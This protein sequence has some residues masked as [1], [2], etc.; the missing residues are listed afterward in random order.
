LGTSAQETGT[1]GAASYG[2][3]GMGLLGLSGQR[4]DS[5]LVSHNPDTV[6]M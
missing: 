4:M 2:V 1:E 6:G 5:S 3:G